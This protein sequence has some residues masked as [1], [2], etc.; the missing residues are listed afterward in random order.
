MAKITITSSNCNLILR[1]RRFDSHR[2]YW[3]VI[4]SK[5][6]VKSICPGNS[7]SISEC[8]FTKVEAMRQY[9]L[10]TSQNE[11]WELTHSDDIWHNYLQV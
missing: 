11:G 4:G 10:L 3:K 1:H 5:V 9:A 6:H 8:V 7:P 2:E